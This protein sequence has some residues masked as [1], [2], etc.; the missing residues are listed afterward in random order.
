MTDEQQR[1]PDA[2][3]DA[4]ST[5]NLNGVGGIGSVIYKM[6]LAGVGALMLAQEEIEAAWKKRGAE[7]GEAT[8]AKPEPAPKAGAPDGTR[9]S[10]QIDGSITRFL[11]TLAIP[12]RDELAA[13]ST[14]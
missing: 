8:D 1:T 6:T 4:T 11:K 12:T 10:N 2:P 13:L 7:K 14:K 5:N 3:N 9:V